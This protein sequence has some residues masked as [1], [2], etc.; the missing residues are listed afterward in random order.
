MR[1]VP[2]PK[3]GERVDER[4]QEGE[5]KRIFRA[6]Q[7]KPA[8]RIRK[9][10]AHELELRESQPPRAADVTMGGGKLAAGKLRRCAAAER[11]SCG[12]CAASMK[13]RR[14]WRRRRRVNDARQ[15]DR[16]LDADEQPLIGLA[17]S[18]RRWTE[19]LI[20]TARVLY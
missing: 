6:E 13:F 17:L 8:V 4:G 1:T 7:E 15:R 20:Q 3:T 11:R 14:R 19:E 2:V 9:S 12:S 5:R 16:K 18:R 10:D